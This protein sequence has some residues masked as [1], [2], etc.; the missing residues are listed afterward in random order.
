MS[1]EDAFMTL[2]GKVIGLDVL[3]SEIEKESRILRT[4]LNQQQ[5][6]ES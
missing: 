1:D 6:E 3:I 5:H 2:K 4:N